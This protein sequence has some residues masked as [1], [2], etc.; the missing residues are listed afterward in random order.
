MKVGI[1]VPASR[2]VSGS[3]V[4]DWAREADKGPFSSL[5]TIDRLVYD[6]FEP[7]TVLSAAAGATQRIRLMTSILL[8]PLRNGGVLAKQAATLDAISGG[9][10]TLGIGVGGREDDYQVAPSPFHDRG[11]RLDEQLALMKRI[12]SGQPV[13]DG[14]GSVGPPPAQFGGP[15]ILIGAFSP[16]ALRRAGQWA[17]GFLGALLP[18]E[19]MQ[20]MH[21]AVR[22]AWEEAGRSGEPRLVAARYYRLGTGTDETSEGYIRD[23]YS[24]AGPMAEQIVQSMLTTPEEIKETIQAYEAVG[25][26][27]VI[28]WP[29]V[30]ELD[31]VHRLADAVG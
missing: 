21:E 22:E 9:R 31:Q 24:F 19:Q 29:T 11:R 20:Q 8:A 10:L 28:L 13:G 16:P 4:L 1:G 6:N 27:E 14:I 7:L 15:E 5:A 12:W 30:A 18:P 3:L 23:Y 26:D 2:G 25:A 17:D